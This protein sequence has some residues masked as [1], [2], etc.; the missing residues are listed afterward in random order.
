LWRSFAR[1]VSIPWISRS[2]IYIATR[3]DRPLMRMSAGR[4]RLSFI[5]PMLLLR[6]RGALSGAIREV[7]LLFVVD[8]DGLLLV[9]S[10]GGG[11]KEPAWCSNLRA[12]P[13]V[14]CLLQGRVQCYQAEEL[15]GARRDSAWDLAVA[16]YPGY[17][18]YQRRITRVIPVFSLSPVPGE[19]ARK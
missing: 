19:M 16:A 2:A 12:H 3:I 1:F 8:E 18:F 6:C 10:R 13:G 5:V 4:I 7:P 9:G 14:E 11:E 15:S 17:G